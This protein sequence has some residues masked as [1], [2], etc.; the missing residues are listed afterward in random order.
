M[1]Y[2]K[3]FFKNNIILIWVQIVLIV[4]VKLVRYLP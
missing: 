4:I 2:N 1:N 3:Q